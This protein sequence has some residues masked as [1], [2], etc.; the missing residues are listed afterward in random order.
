MPAAATGLDSP[1]AD[2]L[3]GLALEDGAEAQL[4]RERAARGSCNRARWT[5]RSFHSRGTGLDSGA[6]S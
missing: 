2:T 6:V 4:F 3:A 1:D 5:R